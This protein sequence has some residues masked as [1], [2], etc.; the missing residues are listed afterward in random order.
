MRGTL[1]AL[2]VGFGLSAA[3][4]ESTGPIE[5]RV[6]VVELDRRAAL[7][8]ADVLAV[9]AGTVVGVDREALRRVT[10]FARERGRMAAQ[11]TLVANSGQRAEFLVGDGVTDLVVRYTAHRG[12]DGELSVDLTFQPP[13]RSGALRGVDLSVRDGGLVAWAGRRHGWLVTV[14]LSDV[15]PRRVQER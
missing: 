15:G 6:L 9:E 5:G 2:A 3:A 1:C 14:E 11:P 8:L 7:A 13:D 4:G 10:E 12:A